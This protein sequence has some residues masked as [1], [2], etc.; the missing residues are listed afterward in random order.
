MAKYN[1]K[2][3]CGHEET[4]QLFGK[5]KDRKRKIDY[6]MNY[7]ICSDCYREQKEIEKSIDCEEKE[8]PYREY[9]TNYSDCKTKAGSYN[10]ET[11]TI[12]VYVPITK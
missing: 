1:V 9:K 4:I 2:F 8:M 6:F 10:G 7:G 3:S 11:K 5:E 12:I